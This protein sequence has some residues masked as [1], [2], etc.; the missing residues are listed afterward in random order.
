[1]ERAITLPMTEALH[2]AP[3]RSPWDGME[4]RPG[5]DFAIAKSLDALEAV[6]RMMAIKRLNGIRRREKDVLEA[7]ASVGWAKDISQKW[8][9]WA[10]KRSE[11]SIS[12][13]LASLERDG[14]IWV[15][16][17]KIAK[18]G[19]RLYLIIISGETILRACTEQ[20]GGQLD[21]TSSAPTPDG[22]IP[23][24]Q[25]DVTSSAPTPDGS[26]TGGGAGDNPPLMPDFQVAGG[27]ALD[28]TSSGTAT[29]ARVPAGARAVRFV[30]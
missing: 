28:V 5:F 18:D 30:C 8:L 29:H 10:T 13:A 2:Q 14:H 3:K 26:N 4:E 20:W 21:V 7:I 27:G 12:H 24:G 23:G 17:P 25:L 11:S 6:D 16:P 22:S 9:Q 15:S 1:M 19:S